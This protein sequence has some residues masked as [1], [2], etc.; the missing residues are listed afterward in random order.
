[1][2]R[3]LYF[4]GGANSFVNCFGNRFPTFK[5]DDGEVVRKVPVPM[6]ALV[7][8]AVSAITCPKALY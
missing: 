4:T 8:T 3:D 5:R 7:A 2:I 6:V 1:M